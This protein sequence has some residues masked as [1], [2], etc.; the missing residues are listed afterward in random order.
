MKLKFKLTAAVALSALL[1][2]GAAMAGIGCQA[3]PNTPYHWSKDGV[4]SPH[5]FQVDEKFCHL[6]LSNTNPTFRVMAIWID[7]PPKHGHVVA[8]GPIPSKRGTSVSY[9]PDP[10][11]K[12]D[13]VVIVHIDTEVNGQPSYPRRAQWRITVQ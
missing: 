12:G 13:D 2:S 9:I 10:G 3:D 6:T 1:T 8:D 4:N 7:Q 5:T 11:F